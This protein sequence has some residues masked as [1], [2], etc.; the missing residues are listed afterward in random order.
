MMARAMPTRCCSPVESS[1]GR[2]RS[3][4]S[5]PDLVERRTHALV[6]LAPGH[7]RD[8]ERQGDVVRDGSIEQELMVLEHYAQAAAELRRC[9]AP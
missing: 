8:D 9:R 1:S 4:P 7:A 2:L 6:D 3:L 5:K